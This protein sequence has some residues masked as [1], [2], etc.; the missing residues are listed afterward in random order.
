MISIAVDKVRA[1]GYCVSV[2]CVTKLA[3][4]SIDRRDHGHAVMDMLLIGDCN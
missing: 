3:G 1:I 2:N 4:D